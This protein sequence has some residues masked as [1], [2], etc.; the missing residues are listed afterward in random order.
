MASYHADPFAAVGGRT[1]LTAEGMHTLEDPEL[2][3]KARREAARAAPVNRM[4]ESSGSSGSRAS[5]RQ[6]MRPATIMTRASQSL[7]D[8]PPP[9]YEETDGRI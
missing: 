3:Q 1:I 5:R 2:V 7:P 6:S 4:G 8:V 9:L